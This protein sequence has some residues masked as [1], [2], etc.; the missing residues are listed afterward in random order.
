MCLKPCLQRQNTSSSF[1]APTTAGFMVN[2]LFLL[3]FR[4]VTLCCT[5]PSA[6]RCAECILVLT[7]YLHDMQAAAGSQGWSWACDPL[8]S[9]S[10]GTFQPKIYHDKPKGPTHTSP[11]FSNPC[12]RKFVNPYSLHLG[13]GRPSFQLCRWYP[14]DRRIF[15]EKVTS[16]TRP[17]HRFQW[18]SALSGTG[19]TPQ[20]CKPQNGLEDDLPPGYGHFG[21]PS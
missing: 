14:W 13:P 1:G 21:V 8:K 7:V 12:R 20:S 18:F 17:R 9:G 10:S 5:S 3:L 11:Y 4:T 19:F 6:S 15:Q 2:L 16:L